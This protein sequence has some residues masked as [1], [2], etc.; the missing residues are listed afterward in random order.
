MLS[1]SPSLCDL[2]LTIQC[3]DDY[4]CKI[5]CDDAANQSCNHTTFNCSEQG[6]C[7][8]LCAGQMQAC[9]DAILNCGLDGCT[10]ACFGPDRPDVNCNADLACSCP[11]PGMCPP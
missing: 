5:R 10:A 9:K 1:T 8:L 2:V 6:R 4:D 7:D 3:P 11:D